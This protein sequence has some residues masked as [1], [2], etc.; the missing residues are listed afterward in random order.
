MREFRGPSLLQIAMPMGGIGAGCICLNGYGGIQD[1]S[2]RNHPATSAL[3]D[4]H[5]FSDAA[6]A[7]L[8]IKGEQPATR[9]VEGPFPGEKVYNLGLKSQG[10]RE[11]GFEGLPRFQ[12]A[13]FT[14]RYPFGT[15]A[16]EDDHLPL[17]ATITGW[18]PLIP[19]D[20]LASGLP[21]AIL[22]YAFENRSRAAVDFEFSCHLSHLAPPNGPH[23]T[24]T[25]NSI[26]GPVGDAGG[27][28]LFS[29]T[30]PRYREDHGSAALYAVGQ[31]PKIKA[32][33]FRGS[34]FDGISVLWRE[35]SAGRFTEN[36]GAAA[37]GSHGRNGGSLLMEGSLAP[38]E[39]ATFPIL[40]AWHFPNSNLR[41]GEAPQPPQAEGCGPDCACDTATMQPAWSPFYAGHF[42]DA[43][44]VAGYV[45]ER[46]GE[47]RARTEAFADALFTSTL[48]AEAVDAVSSN[49]AILK[50]PTVLRQKN[51]NV[52]GWEGC[53]PESG[54]CA[55]SCTHVWNYAQALPHLFPA[56][57]RTLRE[58][59]LTRSMDERGHVTFRSALPDG[60]T[61]HKFHAAAD[62]QLGGILK[63][64]RDYQICGDR[65]WLAKLYPLAKRSLDFC[66]ESWDPERKGLL[67]EPHHNTYDIEF[68]GPDGMCS[69]IY[70]GALSA[71]AEL[72]REVGR[73]DEAPAYEE[74]AARGAQ[75]MDELLFNGE[76]YQQRVIWREAR[77]PSLR[78]RLA[79]GDKPRNPELALLEAEGPKYQYGAGCLADG[80]IGGW[81]AKVYGVETPLNRENIQATLRAIFKHNFKRDLSEH[82]CLQRPGYAIG[83][84]GGLVLC[85]WPRGEKLTLPFPYSDEVWTGI[86]YQVASHLIEEGMVEEGLEIVRAARAR[87]DG[88]TRNPFNE[89]ECG[90]YYARAMASYALLNSLSGFRYSA[91]AGTLW[92]GPKLAADPFRS[93]FSTDSAFGT[94]TLAAVEVEVQVI[95]GELLIERLILTAAGETREIAWSATIPAGESR[96]VSVS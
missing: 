80:I 44:A 78:D 79:N 16:L 62:G 6:F 77:D 9:L 96:S 11:G 63:L 58:Q 42:A 31:S 52:W 92:F 2:I 70:I 69:S 27:G 61:E 50:S 41:K 54:C 39:T 49:L 47:L 5:G 28:I 51:G 38:G 55:G 13:A 33:W 86:E 46:Y 23:W 57:E 65:E 24:E 82:A 20:D 75:L 10:Y 12:K 14:A 89:Y 34:W 53:F 4:G 3:P 25:R 83:H 94:I 37:D 56:L 87:Y 91:P 93:F 71:M 36:D 40:I 68:W 18:T 67:F 45:A 43:G 26:M 74:L 95:E 85:T 59:E 88:H 1:F 7:I 73:P 8:H 60:P 90:S 48:P 84:E 72:A 19:R 32:M 21:C 81:M 15:V 22:E 64:Y 66:I 30:A 76:Y 17:A 35:V 29:N